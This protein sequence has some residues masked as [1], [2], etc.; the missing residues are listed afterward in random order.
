MR[1]ISGKLKGKKL[2][3]LK[4]NTTRPLKDSVKEGIFNVLA[5]SNLL[6]IRI[7]SSI[8][9]DLYSGIGSFGLECLS[10]GAEKVFFVEKDKDATEVLNKNIFNLSMQ[11][12]TSI[13]NDQIENFLKQNI[14]QK[15]EII[16]LDPPF[17]K[18]DYLENL[19]SIKNKNIFNNNHVV[20]LHRD[21]K[22]SDNYNDVLNVL[23]VKEYGRSKIIFGNF[24]V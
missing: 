16:F 15:F 9:L 22:S 19:K 10:R 7:A 3:F 21:S 2:F 24:L 13:T 4:S 23:L 6:N 12:Q 17:A 20:I 18:I 8:V 5:H 11:N 14:L 1:I